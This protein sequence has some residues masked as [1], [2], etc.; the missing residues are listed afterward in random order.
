MVVLTALTIGAH[1]A[2]GALGANMGATHCTARNLG[3]A[4][5]TPNSFMGMVVCGSRCTIVCAV[6]AQVFVADGAGQ[7][8]PRLGASF[9]PFKALFL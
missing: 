5:F 6:S 9:A 4:V 1:I 7:R 8:W 3:D 2:T